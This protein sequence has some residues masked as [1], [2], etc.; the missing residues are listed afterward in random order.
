MK[1]TEWCSCPQ[2]EI[3]RQID[4]R[5]G[6]THTPVTSARQ[7]MLEHCREMCPVMDETGQNGAYMLTVT[8]VGPLPPGAI[9]C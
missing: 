7:D 3:S 6:L 8:H 2:F 5:I 1:G 4:L 9:L